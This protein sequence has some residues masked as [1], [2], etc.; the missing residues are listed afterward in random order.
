MI[1]VST[2]SADTYITNKF[3][4]GFTKK[5]SNTGRSG[6]LDL[7]KLFNHPSAPENS[8]ELSRILIKF[9][10]QK[11]EQLAQQNRF[12]LNGVVSILKLRSIFAGQAVPQNFTISVFPLAKPFS[13]GIGRDVISFSD[14]DEANFLSSSISEAWELEGAS[15]S[16]SLGDVGVDYYYQGDLLDGSGVQSFELTQ[17]FIDGTEELEIDIS[18]FVS[19]SISGNLTNYGF[20]ISFSSN[21]ETDQNNYFA[22]RFSSRHVKN[23]FQRPRVENY[24]DDSERDNREKLTFN[25]SGS[26]YLTN[27]IG[28]ERVRLVSGSD[29]IQGENCLLLTLSTGSFETTFDVSES[30]FRQ[31]TYLANVF[32]S[33]FDDSIVSGSTTLFQYIQSSSSITFQEKWTS[34]DQSVVFQSNDLIINSSKI[35]QGIFE[36]FELSVFTNG[37]ETGVKDSL[38]LIRPKFY[39][40]NLQDRSS[41]F[42]F[43]KKPI[44]LKGTYRIVDG[45]TGEIYIDFNELNQLSYDSNGNYFEI[46]SDSIPYGR[47]VNFE[48]KIFYLGNERIIKDRNYTFRTGE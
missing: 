28:G 44:P 29:Q 19:A 5:S 26:L 16:G 47:T 30:P 46:H 38:V 7:F 31:G 48:Y 18:K 8:T 35:S 37:P 4:D 39:D 6:T 9:D 10:Y 2:S 45:T 21:E 25:T 15:L 14:I 24:F 36:N 11:L 27:Q 13:E 22:K 34:L 17:S 3:V 41:K 1:I 43:A 32:V 40:L 23:S 12:D 42:A 33:S 20:R